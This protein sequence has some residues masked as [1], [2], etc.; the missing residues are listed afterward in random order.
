MSKRSSKTKGS[1]LGNLPHASDGNTDRLTA[2][3]V[4][5]FNQ[6]KHAEA[7]ELLETVLATQQRVLGSSHPDTLT[8]AQSLEST[9]L[10]VLARAA[11]PNA[12]VGKAAGRR[13]QPFG[14]TAPAKTEANATASDAELLVTVELGDALRDHHSS[15]QATVFA[16]GWNNDGQCGIN[17]GENIL[18]PTA[19]PL[20][21]VG[22]LAASPFHS[23]FL[24]SDQTLFVCG[25][26][27][28]LG[29]TDAEVEAAAG[30]LVHAAPICNPHMTRVSAI[31]CGSYHT[32]AVDVHGKLWGW[33]DNSCGQLATTK[34][35]TDSELVTTPVRIPGLAEILTVACGFQFTAV[36]VGKHTRALLTFGCN[37]FGQL[38]LNTTEPTVTNPSRVAFAD[39]R[40]LLP[41]QQ[42]SCGDYHML[43]LLQASGGVL[44]CGN[45]TYGRCGV[46]SGVTEE[47]VEGTRCRRVLEYVSE[48]DRLGLCVA[49]VCAG[50]ASSAAIT[51]HGHGSQLFTWGCNARGQLGLGH[52]EDTT[53]PACVRTFCGPVIDVG[54]GSDHMVVIACVADDASHVF[55]CGFGNSGRLGRAR[56]GAAGANGDGNCS[57]LLPLQWS[58][59]PGRRALALVVSGAHSFVRLSVG[60]P[61]QHPQ[62]GTAPCENLKRTVPCTNEGCPT[63]L[64]SFQ[65]RD[66]H[67][68][69]CEFSAPLCPNSGCGV[70]F[71]SSKMAQHAAS[72]GHRVI[73]CPECNERMHANAL[74]EHSFAMCP[75][76]RTECPYREHGCTQSIMLTR[77]KLHMANCP[78]RPAASDVGL[79]QLPSELPVCS[80]AA[81][82]D[83]ITFD[84]TSCDVATSSSA[85]LSSLR[86]GFSHHDLGAVPVESALQVTPLAGSSSQGRIAP[87]DKKRN[88][89]RRTGGG[90]TGGK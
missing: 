89:T 5:L 69:V 45:L 32:M 44:A 40:Q 1:R 81:D 35:V 63:L 14:P 22:A 82:T 56:A 7:E 16:W 33:G 48:F 54:M 52:C 20:R 28:H 75:F 26:Q 85:D 49:K 76:R 58:P 17:P 19:V 79:D 30:L 43:V 13:Q 84:G 15:D 60:G 90:Y 27:C 62:A 25:S 47:Y 11:Q 70:R 59:P 65:Q 29:L 2:E 64:A 10:P 55:T 53:V 57:E 9:R 21:D 36:V 77:L 80:T 41:V 3:A 24:R 74:A 8:I 73:A 67:V 50:G 18:T 37:R 78:K 39:G 51:V 83:A 66:R 6:G 34:A 42:V 88:A 86:V 68:A 31:A 38:G 4:S 71:P 46:G 72:C 23:V 61:A 87:G 12:K